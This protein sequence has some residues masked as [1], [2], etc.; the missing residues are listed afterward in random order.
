[1]NVTQQHPVDVIE[2]PPLP[3]QLLDTAMTET[4]HETVRMKAVF[5]QVVANRAEGGKLLVIRT[6]IMPCTVCKLT[7]VDNISW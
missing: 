7:M 4:E 2:L 6:T 5:E 1:M 3:L